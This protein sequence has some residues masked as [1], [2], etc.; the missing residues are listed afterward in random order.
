MEAWTERVAEWATAVGPETMPAGLPEVFRRAVLDTLACMIAGTQEAPGRILREWVREEGGAPEARV[1]GEVTRV[2]APAAA[3]VNGTLGHAL[4]Y[5]DVNGAVHGHPSTV[6]VPAVLAVAERADR[7][8]ASALAGYVAGVEV[9]AALGRALGHPHYERGW[10]ATATLG[11]V[12]AAVA[13]GRVLGLT[14]EAMRRAIGIAVSQAGGVRRNFGTMTKPLHAGL[15]AKN[16][17]VA[18][19]LAA[20]GYE[21]AADALEAPAGF[22]AVFAGDMAPAE[23]EAAARRALADL[24]QSWALVDPGL[25]VKRY[26]CCYATH[27]ALDAMLEIVA[28]ARPDP[29]AVRAVR[30]RVPPGGLVPLIYRYAATGLEGKFSMAYVMAAALVDGQVGLATFTDA[31]VARETVQ[32]L[33]RRV[34]AEEDPTLGQHGYGQSPTRAGAVVVDVTLADG[35]RLERAVTAARGSA[36]R[37]LSWEE[38]AAKLEDAVRWSGL[39]LDAAALAE[40]VRGLDQAPSVR[41][42]AEVLAGGAAA[43]PVGERRG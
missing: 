35:R 3:W 6:V 17:V 19:L 9:M 22:F 15:A 26:P 31:A 42:W 7:D 4:D 40:A 23:A 25:D 30:V 1:V 18:A 37:P 12:G 10:H 13:A 33:Q 14:A 8:G 5:D 28:E 43:R 29:E 32:R 21:A 24:G 34:T 27:R 2:P 11:T 41:R 20:R 16:G 39:A 38:L 36:L